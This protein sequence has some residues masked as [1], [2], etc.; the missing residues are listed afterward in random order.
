VTGNEIILEG[1]LTIAK[2][3]ALH[4]QLETLLQDHSKICIN[5]TAVE[6][7][8]TSIIQLLSSLCNSADDVNVEL[9]LLA[10]EGLKECTTLLGFNSL[11][12]RYV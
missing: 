11:K 9:K 1:A 7:A 2:A 8:D 3:E 6:R 12:E 5:A 10:S 4:L